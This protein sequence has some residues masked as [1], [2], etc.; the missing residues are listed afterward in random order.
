METGVKNEV[1]DVVNEKNT[2]LA[3]GSGCLNVYATPAM[4]AL[5][6]KAAAELM[7]DL[8]DN[9]CTTVGISLNIKHNAATPMGMKVRATAELVA[10]DGRRLSFVV[11][12]YDEDG[13]IGKGIHDRFVVHKEKFQA[14]TD[15]KMAK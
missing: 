15:S 7:E 8:V 4:C 1:F 14:K 2:A 11:T 5:M 10:I 13:E 9:G 6:E 12:A 3:M